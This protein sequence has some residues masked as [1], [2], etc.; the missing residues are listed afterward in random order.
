M[1]RMM[2][3]MWSRGMQGAQRCD[4]IIAGTVRVPDRWPVFGMSYLLF[5]HY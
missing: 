3:R 5:N 4:Q 2:N 1:I